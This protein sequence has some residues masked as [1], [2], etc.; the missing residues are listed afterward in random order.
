MKHYQ[1]VML[2]TSAVGP[3]Q[4]RTVHLERNNGKNEQP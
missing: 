3:A 2:C 4:L 1:H